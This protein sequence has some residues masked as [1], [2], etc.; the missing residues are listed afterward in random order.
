MIGLKK[1][2]GHLQLAGEPR[3]QLLPP[4]V[5]LRTKRR[6][7]RQLLGLLT[8][9][10]IVIV[11]AGMTFGLFRSTTAQ[12]GLHAERLRSQQILADQAEYSEVVEIS[13]I[14]AMSEDA[15]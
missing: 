13:A 6:E 12:A 11:A 15:Q 14:V 1:S 8:V 2:G 5:R 9:L 4:S 3:V 7:T 10:A